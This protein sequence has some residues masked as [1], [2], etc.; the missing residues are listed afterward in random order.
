M[1]QTCALA[2]LAKA[3]S[4]IVDQMLGDVLAGKHG[5]LLRV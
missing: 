5:F 2:D 4:M 1:E 3:I